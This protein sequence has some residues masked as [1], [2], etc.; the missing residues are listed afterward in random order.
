M[1]K[2]IVDPEELRR[3]AGELRKSTHEMQARMS[4]LQARMS[5]LSETWKDQEQARFAE[6]FDQ[7]LKV[8]GRF[9][10]AAEVHVPFLMRKADRID[11]YLNQR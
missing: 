5:Q 1:A 6:E 10:K 11:E 9:V 8:L 7:T 4:G 2:A 3:F